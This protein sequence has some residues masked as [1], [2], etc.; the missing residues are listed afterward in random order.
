MPPSGS[1]DVHPPERQHHAQHL[2][3]VLAAALNNWRQ[4][5]PTDV[6][7]QFEASI[8]PNPGGVSQYRCRLVSSP[9]Q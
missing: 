8:S 3:D 6:I 2:N 5:D 9:N 1:K 7:I 4:G